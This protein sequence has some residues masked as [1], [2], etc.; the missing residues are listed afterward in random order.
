MPVESQ[1]PTRLQVLH[2]IPASAPL[3]DIE[4]LRY[5][6]KDGLVSEY[7][8][9]INSCLKRL[10]SLSGGTSE[11]H[12]KIRLALSIAC[13]T[14][15]SMNSVA[16]EYGVHHTQVARS[17]RDTLA[18]AFYISNTMPEYGV[19]ETVLDRI[20]KLQGLEE[21]LSGDRSVSE[22]PVMNIYLRK[23]PHVHSLVQTYLRD[24]TVKFL[25]DDLGVSPYSSYQLRSVGRFLH[26]PTLDQ[27]LDGLSTL[28]TRYTMGRWLWRDG[29]F[30]SHSGDELVSLSA[31]YLFKL[32]LSGL[33]D[34]E[35]S[36]IAYMK[37]FLSHFM[38]QE[39][40]DYAQYQ[41]ESEDHGESFFP[42]K[43]G[44]VAQSP[45]DIDVGAA[46]ARYAAE[47][48]TL[49]GIR[50]FGEMIRDNYPKEDRIASMHLNENY[51]PGMLDMLDTAGV[52]FLE[53]TL[54]YQSVN[55]RMTIGRFM[56][57]T[58]AVL[59]RAWAETHAT[60]GR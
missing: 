48:R 2:E 55:K 16:N 27:A 4:A 38:K 32:D 3:Y 15:K 37:E 54:K 50:I 24:G 11:L 26:N 25:L 41:F 35:A 34:H 43:S 30:T 22:H 29:Y 47:R 46:Y 58:T 1:H 36:Q 33:P 19:H 53:N 56:Q 7:G 42:S 18:G 9:H 51:P 21:V 20:Y 5:F 12:P 8:V 14:G 40:S 57:D 17:I 28:A 13:S 6:V 52:T 23:I 49:F 31:A 39:F 59:T 45:E 10:S 60:L 44:G